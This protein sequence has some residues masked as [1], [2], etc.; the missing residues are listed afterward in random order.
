VNQNPK[1]NAINLAQEI[2][3]RSKLLSPPAQQ[4]GLSTIKDFTAE[5]LARDLS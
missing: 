5:L 4:H 3:E 1:V 2:A